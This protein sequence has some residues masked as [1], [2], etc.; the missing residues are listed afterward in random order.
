VIAAEHAHTHY[1]D[2]NWIVGLQGWTPA[3]WL[4]KELQIVNGMRGKDLRK[5][6]S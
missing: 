6:Q 1:G 3:T 5:R 2:G 4:P